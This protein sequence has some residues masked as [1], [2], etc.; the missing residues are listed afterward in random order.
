MSD[1]KYQHYLARHHMSWFANGDGT[2]SF[3][4]LADG[5]LRDRVKLTEI[6]G[7]KYLYESDELPKNFVEKQIL[8]AVLIAAEK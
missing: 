1:V 7:Q 6:G 5:K 8:H 2:N 3:W 4:S